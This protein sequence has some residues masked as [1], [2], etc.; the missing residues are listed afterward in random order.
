VSRPEGEALLRVEELRTWFPIR[1]G[2]LQ[3]IVGW[4]RAV[5]G[6]DLEIPAGR[7]LALVGE[8]GCG[9][10]TVGRSL[11]RLVEPR[12]GRLLFDGVDLLSLSPAALRPYRRAMQI[13]FQDPT[14]SLD[15]R[16]MVRDAIAE[17]MQAFGIGANE[18]ERT[19][20]VAALLT[21]VQLDAD[22]MW[23]YPHEFSGGQ[24]QRLCIAR[25]LAVEP[26][27][28]IC[29]EATSALDVSIQAQILNLL[30]DLQEELGLAYLF[31]T[32]DLGVVRYLA[33]RVAVMYLGQIVEEGEAERIFEDP[34]HPYTRGLLAAVP[35]AD[36]TK[37]G[38]VLRVRGDVPSPSNPPAGCRFHTRCPDVFARC[39]REAPALYPVPDGA[40]RCF[41]RDPA[42]PDGDVLG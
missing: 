7:T 22:Q 41:L 4:V 21:R 42:G 16:M 34:Q 33:D 14:A 25:A 15:P 9:K 20:R 13:V 6:V 31:I 27:L 37:R 24:R 10:S 39:D 3:R 36:P 23:R 17:G 28:V 40:S 30:S 35:S 19:E 26:R 2:V 38:I 5:D 18:A 29:D 32:H 1:A 8:S 12:S 11:L